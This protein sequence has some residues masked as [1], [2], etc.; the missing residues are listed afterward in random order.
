MALSIIE[1]SFTDAS[2]ASNR[3]NHISDTMRTK[4]YHKPLNLSYSLI[5]SWSKNVRIK[6]KIILSKKLIH[7][8]E[9]IDERDWMISYDEIFLQEFFKINKILY[10]SLTVQWVNVCPIK[11]WI[12][13]K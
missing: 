7:K 2:K 6:Y 9:S 11:D 12:P 10:S 5:S 4:N 1:L 8:F 13:I 3:L